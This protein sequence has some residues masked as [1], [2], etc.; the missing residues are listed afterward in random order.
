MPFLKG[1]REALTR[2]K[3][4]LDAGKIILKNDIKIFSINYNPNLDISMGTN[5]FVTWHLPQIQFKNPHV[6]VSM[7]EN[8]CPT[9]FIRCYFADG[10]EM[11]VNCS[12]RTQSEI[13]D[14]V[15][16]IF[17]K[18]EAQLHQESIENQTIVNPAYFGYRYPRQCLCEVYGQVPCPSKKK[19][20]PLPDQE[21][22]A[23]ELWC[24]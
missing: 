15:K 10:S 6:Q 5:K 17:G 19:P 18:T 1:G 14:H 11:L 8:L 16:S 4:F 23:E 24:V 7:F 22:S 9:P 13:H 20:P 2:T 12:F 3:K 21:A